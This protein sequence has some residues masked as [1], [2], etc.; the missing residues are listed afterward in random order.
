[1]NEHRNSLNASK[2][3]ELLENI[4]AKHKSALKHGVAILAGNPALVNKRTHSNKITLI[5]QP[6]SFEAA[7]IAKKYFEDKNI[8]VFIS[9]LFDHQ[10]HWHLFLKKCK[11]GY[12]NGENPLITMDDLLEEIKLPYQ[13]MCDTYGYDVKS[14]QVIF[15]ETCR[16]LTQKWLNGI[17][18]GSE[19]GLSPTFAS[20]YSALIRKVTSKAD[21]CTTLQER[22]SCKGVAGQCILTTNNYAGF[23]SDKFGLFLGCW[24]NDPVRCDQNFIIG[25]KEIAQKYWNVQSEIINVILKRNETEEPPITFYIEE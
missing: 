19:T 6:D 5:Q 22:V 13:K 10:K 15:E 18:G 17:R 23:G 9:I 8:S 14:F 20:L 11:L 24:E 25:G 16:E 4:S 2:V 1:M 21:G 3:I 12:L 7:L